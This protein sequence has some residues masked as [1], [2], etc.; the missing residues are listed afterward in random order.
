M[1]DIF[2]ALIGNE[3]LCARFA[4]ALLSD[5]PDLP[6]AYIIE[7]AY[8]TGKHTLALELARALTC[9]TRTNTSAS[10]LP[11]GEC[12]SCRNISRGAA[13]DII[14]IQKDGASVG[15]DAIRELRKDIH[16]S[17]I[18]L[19]RKIYIINDAHTMTAQAQ[20]ALLLT[21]EEPPSYAFILLLCENSALLLETIKSRAPTVRMKPLS[22]EDTEK[23]LLRSD[24]SLENI[25]R[26]SPALWNDMIMSSNGSAGLAADLLAGNEASRISEMRRA[27]EKFCRLAADSSKNSELLVHVTEVCTSLRETAKAQLESFLLAIRDITLLKRD[28]DAPLRFYSDRT[29]AIELSDS[30]SLRRLLKISDAL[31]EAITSLERN[32]NTK[33]TLISM[34]AGMEMLH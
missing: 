31:L 33:L 2:P 20:N 27:S 21:L 29:F 4:R 10:A 23:A 8:G 3:E 19:E 24:P 6:H 32:M 1:K 22:P 7:G 34:L 13:P 30:F 26:S 28:G 16:I 9:E 15:V 14:E 11:C 17:P 12:R 25:R 5:T 18:D